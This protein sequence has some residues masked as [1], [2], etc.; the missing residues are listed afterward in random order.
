ME[1]IQQARNVLKKFENGNKGDSKEEYY[2]VNERTSIF[3][4]G[5]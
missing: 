4:G 5:E 2:C 1:D 3:N